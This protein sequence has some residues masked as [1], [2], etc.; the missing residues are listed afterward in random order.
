M[1][2]TQLCSVNPASANHHDQLRFRRKTIRP[3]GRRTHPGML[4]DHQVQ[5][6]SI[7]V[8]LSHRK[9]QS[10][11]IP[12]DRCTEPQVTPTIS[13]SNTSADTIHAQAPLEGQDIEE[14]TDS[15]IETLSHRSFSNASSDL[16]NNIEKE[17]VIEL[18]TIERCMPRAYIRVCLA[19]RLAHQKQVPLVVQRLNEFI[20]KT[21]DAKPYL[22]GYVVPQDKRIS[23]GPV[24]S[25]LR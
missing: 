20:H 12:M 2:L 22:A 18:S 24:E 8:A 21:V 1:I 10:D 19:Y 13:Q 4:S 11:L 9:L 23:T 7:G 25:T 17:H 3:L 16:H 15:P 6:N 5:G 14:L